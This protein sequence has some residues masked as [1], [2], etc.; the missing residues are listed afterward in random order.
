MRE[1][2]FVSGFA[3]GLKVIESFGE[4]RQRL[5]IA[6]AAKLTEL[7][8][9]TVRR[10][11]LTLAELGYA[12]YDGKFFTLTPKILRLGHA[13]LSATPLP[14]LLQPHLD[15]LSERAGQSASAS[16]LDGTE[17]VYIARASQ[18]RVMSI[19][20]TPGSRLPAYCASMGR[21]LL[22]ALPESEACAV[23]ARS[24]LK[25]NTA[26]TKT[27]PEELIAEFRRVRAEGYAI[28]DQELEIG[29][30]SIAVP[31]ENDRG[32]TVAAINIGAPAA[33]VPA[34]DMKERYLK[35]LQET[36]VALRPLLRR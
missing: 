33:L 30:C 32:E 10:S 26:N 6:E 1:T 20:L 3:R 11:L 19:N 22:A 25:R 36:Q 13:Y 17:I 31:V 14:A 21:V 34:A 15:H 35:L 16:V 12:D 18:R 24:E 27:D 28:I 4:T 29:L 8:R 23:L 5:S 7:D 2:D 9:A